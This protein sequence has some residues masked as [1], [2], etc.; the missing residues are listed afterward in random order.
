[1]VDC[2][3]FLPNLQLPSQPQSV[4]TS[5]YTA[6]WQRQISWTPCTDHLS[7]WR[8]FW[9][10]LPNFKKLDYVQNIL[11]QRELEPTTYSWQQVHI[12]P[13]TWLHELWWCHTGLRWW[14]S[15]G[16]CLLQRSR[17][18]QRQSSS[19]SHLVGQRDSGVVQ[20]LLFHHQRPSFRG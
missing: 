11:T 12:L 18:V 2:C 1:M 5:C 13:V 14:A 3:Y 16:R 7:E 6:W 4:T 17:C 19:S 10:T 9:I 20:T 8:N 15:D